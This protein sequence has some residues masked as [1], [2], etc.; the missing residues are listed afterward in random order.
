MPNWCSKFI[1]VSFMYKSINTAQNK[2]TS[3][4]PLRKAKFPNLLSCSFGIIFFD[5]GGNKI[6]DY[7]PICELYA[8]RLNT[9]SQEHRADVKLCDSFAWIAKLETTDLEYLCKNYL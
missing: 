6:Q 2:I 8:P 5:K 9:C 1:E 3:I 7:T 4:T